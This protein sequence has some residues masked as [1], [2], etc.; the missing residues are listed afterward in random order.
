MRK[1]K[2]GLYF[3]YFS[4]LILGLS[5]FFIWRKD[6]NKSADL[7]LRA[8]ISG[9]TLYLEIADTPVLQAK[10]LA[11][12]VYL[13]DDYGMLFIWPQAQKRIFWM[14]DMLVP[15]DI[16]WIKGN[17]IVGIENNIQSEQGVS[18]DRLKKYFSPGPVDKVIEVR[19]NLTKEENFNPGDEIKFFGDKNIN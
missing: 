19:A 17:K 15:I 9:H 10:G 18:D 14:K 16:I 4:I 13:P 5:L 7:S 8:E 1:S 3:L 11:G 2:I 12:K 6:Y